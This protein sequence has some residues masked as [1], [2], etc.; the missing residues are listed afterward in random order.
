[1][2]CTAV[3]LYSGQLVAQSEKSVVTTFTCVVGWWNVVYTTP[4]ATRSVIL[5]FSVVSPERLASFTQSPSRTPRCSASCG[6]ISSTSSSCQTTLAVR[7]VCAPT[8]YCE[9][10]RPVV[11]S[12]G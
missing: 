9:R 3:T 11:S 12:S 2:T 4:G 7:L 6:W 1:M 5:A 8:L 10:M